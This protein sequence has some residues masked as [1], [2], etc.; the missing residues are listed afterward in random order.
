MAYYSSKDAKTVR[1]PPIASAM[2]ARMDTLALGWCSVTWTCFMTWVSKAMAAPLC[3]LLWQKDSSRRRWRTAAGWL[4]SVVDRKGR[5]K[6]PGADK[7]YASQI[8]KA[9]ECP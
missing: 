4:V 6:M 3:C 8:T 5:H 9:Q 7:R 1:G 2:A